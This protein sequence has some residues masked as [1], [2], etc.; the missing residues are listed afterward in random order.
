MQADSKCALWTGDQSEELS[1]LLLPRHYLTLLPG[2]RARAAYQALCRAVHSL[3][4]IS[5]SRA[6]AK[7]EPPFSCTISSTEGESPHP[8]TH[9][10]LLNLMPGPVRGSQQAAR[11]IKGKAL[12]L[13]SLQVTQ[14][15]LHKEE[16]HVP[17]SGYLYS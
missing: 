1:L 6:Q 2:R 13:A 3:F 15:T 4:L 8:V 7:S 9:P 16:M 5:G 12:P 11:G 14:T 10:W 17:G